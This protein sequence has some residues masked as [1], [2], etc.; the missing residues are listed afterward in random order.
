MPLRFFD[1]PD[2]VRREIKTCLEK[3]PRPQGRCLSLPTLHD[4]G[5]NRPFRG[6]FST[7]QLLNPTRMEYLKIT[8]D[9]SVTPSERA[10]ALLG[11]RHHHKLESVA[12]KIAGLDAERFLDG[13]DTGTL[14]LIEPDEMHEGYWHLYDYKTWGSYSVAK[15]M[16]L[17]KNGG[18]YERR[19]VELQL[20][21]YR[22]KIERMG[23]PISRLTVQCTVRDGGTRTAR[24]N[25]VDWKLD[26]IPV[27]RLDDKVV[28]DYFERK[29]ELLYEALG[30]DALPILCD[31]HERW[32]GRRCKGSLCEVHEFCPQG[33]MVNRLPELK[34]NFSDHDPNGPCGNG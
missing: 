32:N 25:N 3:C 24:E 9:Y 10:F 7:T 31:Y 16:G 23:F 11:T 12:K 18:D 20:N 14:D 29:R 27:A 2:N 5:W 15:H 33:R 28:L 8:K 17:M 6:K 1:C 34:T 22:I 4:I 30:D 26:T 13:D 19:Q 21:N